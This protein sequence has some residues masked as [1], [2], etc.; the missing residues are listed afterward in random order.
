MNRIHDR[1][2][3]SAKSIVLIYE[4]ELTMRNKPTIGT[5]KNLTSL[6][7]EISVL[8]RLGHFPLSVLAGNFE[9]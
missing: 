6:W 1:A 4:R 8:I 9:I 5:Q 7:N 2:R 3:S